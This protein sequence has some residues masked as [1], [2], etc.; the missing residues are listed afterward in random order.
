MS[1]SKSITQLRQGVYCCRQVFLCQAQEPGSQHHC[2]I[3]TENPSYPCVKWSC[4]R[5][6]ICPSCGNPELGQ[7]QVPPCHAWLLHGP[8]WMGCWWAI[9]N[10]KNKLITLA[11]L[12]GITT[13]KGYREGITVNFLC[14]SE[15]T[16]F[17]RHPGISKRQRK[18]PLRRGF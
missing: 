10:G 9:H 7:S 15:G 2:I 3:H 12:R 6:H 1:A 13:D 4:V 5:C 11:F 18:G 16:R 14:G 8:G 17:V